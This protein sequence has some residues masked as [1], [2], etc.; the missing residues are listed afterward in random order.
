M[1]R[2]TLPLS[3]LLV[4]PLTLSVQ[5]QKRRQRNRNEGIFSSNLGLQT[6]NSKRFFVLLVEY[7]ELLSRTDVSVSVNSAGRIL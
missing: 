2:I 1:N 4:L 7:S 5:A 3:L 6:N